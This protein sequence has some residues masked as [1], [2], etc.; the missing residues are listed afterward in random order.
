MHYRCAH[1]RHIIKW[2]RQ[3]LDKQEKGD[4]GQSHVSGF[5]LCHTFTAQAHMRQYAR[6]SLSGLLYFCCISEF[7]GVTSFQNIDNLISIEIQGWVLTRGS[8]EFTQV[9]EIQICQII[10]NQVMWD[11][12]GC[13]LDWGL[14]V[15][16]ANIWF[17]PNTLSSMI[18]RCV[19]REHL[20]KWPMKSIVTA[21]C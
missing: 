8:Q 12:L 17:D 4:D 11:P 10:L 18:M 7:K 16:M 19:T 5:K 1:C 9:T 14:R 6:T 13:A 21:A 15:N 3:R 20:L 2:W